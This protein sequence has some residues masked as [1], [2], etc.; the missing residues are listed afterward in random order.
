M[1][2]ICVLGLGYIGLPTASLFARNGFDVTGVDINE[3]IVATLNTGAIHIDEAGL[4]ELVANVV[5][6]GNLRA[7][8]SPVASDAFIIAVP[9]PFGS[10]KK[11]DL[12][13][14]FA[15]VDSILPL[16]RPGNLV[17]VESTVPPG[18]AERVAGYI[19]RKRKDLGGRNSDPSSLSVHVVHCPERVLPGNILRELVE[20]D[21]VI[22]GLTPKG[23][24]LAKELYGRIIT[25]K[26]YLTDATTAEMVKLSENTF[27]D[28]NIA[29][30][31]ELA[32]ISEKLGINIWEV[33]E[34]A[35]KH[36]RVRFLS[37]GPGVGGHCIA[38]DPWFIASDFPVEAKVIRAA[39]VRND[40]VPLR[41][42]NKVKKIL[43]KT[44]NPK[45]AC[46]GG[47]YK[48]NVGDA[49]NSPALDIYK[50]LR[51]AYGKKGKVVLCDRHLDPAKFTLS[52]IEDSLQGA[53]LVLVLVDHNEFKNL[54]PELAASL[55]RAR[56]ILDTRNIIDRT[57]WKA[58]GFTCHLL[59]ATGTA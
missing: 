59:G 31:N 33:V 9:T 39:R 54:S 44:R 55:V 25:G 40:G 8:T 36:P 6:S 1:N 43:S 45:I 7:S 26:I 2:S 14:V 23:S 27:R 42:V 50:A 3:K 11:P 38:V 24:E 52:S 34:L 13:F 57:T 17:I 37:P 58:S 12:K 5:A 16:L 49:R 41:V 47:S 28:V 29:L 48:G 56:V 46:L 20:N 15:A 18:T 21:R 22:G 30:S 19:Q 53:D 10:K 51:K 35:N 4:H 32:L